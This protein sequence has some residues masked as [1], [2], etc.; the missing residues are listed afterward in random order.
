M[1]PDKHRCPCENSSLST[2]E[3][4]NCTV[5]FPLQRLFSES[6]IAASAIMFQWQLSLFPF[7]SL[8]IWSLFFPL[9]F[10]KGITCLAV[11]PKMS[12]KNVHTC[13]FNFRIKSVNLAHTTS[14]SWRLLKCSWQEEKV[15]WLTQ[16]MLIE[17]ETCVWV[18]ESYW[19]WLISTI[20]FF[21]LH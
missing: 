20:I 16:V 1:K 2:S 19:K 5:H 7:F 12:L 14:F 21:H 8:L 4:W 13:C 6:F 15:N 17:L 3:S 18:P 11:L 10:P 9:G